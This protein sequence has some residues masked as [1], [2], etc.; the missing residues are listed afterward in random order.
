MWFFIFYRARS[1]SGDGYLGCHTDFVRWWFRQ[2]GAALLVRLRFQ[3]AESAL[4]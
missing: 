4:D 3:I 2:D 1:V